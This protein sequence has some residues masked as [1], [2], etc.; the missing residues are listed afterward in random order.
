MNRRL[1]LIAA[2]ALTGGCAT[3]DQIPVTHIL[4]PGPIAPVPARHAPEAFTETHSEAAARRE[5]RPGQWAATGAKYGFGGPALAALRMPL[6][7]PLLPFVLPVT[8]IGGAVVGGLSGAVSASRSTQRLPEDQAAPLADMVAVSV[9]ERLQ[10]AIASCFV[11]VADARPEYPVVTQPAPDATVLELAVQRAG[12]IA[13][14]GVPPRAA[15]DIELL[16]RVVPPGG[17]REPWTREFSYGGD[18]RDSAEWQ[19]EDG[20]VMATELYEACDELARRIAGAIFVKPTPREA[21]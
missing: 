16:V 6:F 10:A 11:R 17:V 3:A 14:D 2:L 12:L 13:T 8:T 21:S 1:I 18:Y 7:L 19:D 4:Q 20:R 5:N 15:L 9:D